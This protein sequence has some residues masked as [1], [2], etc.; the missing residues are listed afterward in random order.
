MFKVF[1]QLLVIHSP[2]SVYFGKSEPGQSHSYSAEILKSKRTTHKKWP[3]GYFRHCYSR[4]R[5]IDLCAHLSLIHSYKQISGMSRNKMTLWWIC[6]STHDLPW[7]TNVYLKA[8]LLFLENLWPM[9]WLRN[10]L[11]ICF[12]GHV[13]FA[14]FPHKFI[15]T[16]N[17]VCKLRDYSNSP[18]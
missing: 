9:S 7:R 11:E 17:N 1:S 14:T 8:T 16:R 12:I 10:C 3:A 6:F 18:G 5:G 2:I 13:I 15:Q 4:S